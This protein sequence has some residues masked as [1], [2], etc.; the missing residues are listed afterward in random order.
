MVTTAETLRTIYD[1][2]SM[3]QTEKKGRKWAREYLPGY[4]GFVPTKNDLFGKTAGSINREI[5]VAGGKREELDRMELE[6]HREQ[7]SG[8][9]AKAEINSDVF[10]NH[11]RR[12]KNWINGPTNEIRQQHIPGYTGHC[13]GFVNKDFMSKSY[14]KVTAELFARNH[15]MGDD[16]DQRSRFTAT[17]RAAF[18]PQNFRRWGK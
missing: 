5:C 7:S 11:S 18:K 4:T 15:P 1:N 9:P 6:R 16:T 3:S 17:Q 8:L 12:S 14:A 2:A 13:R 10:G